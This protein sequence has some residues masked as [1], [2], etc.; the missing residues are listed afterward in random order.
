MKKPGE[1]VP[2]DTLFQRVWETNYFGDTRTLDVHISWL[3][4][5]LEEDPHHPE[6]ILTVRSV[7]YK[8][9]L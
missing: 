2:R 4:H 3:R 5:A 9:D 7:G 6:L 8:L 1:V